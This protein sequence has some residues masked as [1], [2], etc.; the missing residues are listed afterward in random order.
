MA[1]AAQPLGLDLAISGVRKVRQAKA[2][3]TPVRVVTDLPANISKATKNF[4]SDFIRFDVKN[5]PVSE[6]RFWAEFGA[7]PLQYRFEV[8]ED[9]AK[10]LGLTET[11]LSAG[12]TAKSILDLP[13]HDGSLLY[14]VS[15]EK[16]VKLGWLS[17]VIFRNL[18]KKRDGFMKQRWSARGRRS[19]RR[20]AEALGVLFR[21]DRL[22]R[23][24]CADGRDPLRILERQLVWTWQSFAEADGLDHED[25][26]PILLWPGASTDEVSEIAFKDTIH[27]VFVCDAGCMTVG[28]GRHGWWRSF[29]AL[30]YHIAQHHHREAETQLQFY[31][32]GLVYHPTSPTIGSHRDHGLTFFDG[33]DEGLKLEGLDMKGIMRIARPTVLVS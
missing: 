19:R 24:R 29:V 5:L 22:D 10:L 20:A 33:L 1:E 27:T 21:H 3:T 2:V 13:P 18:D 15:G 4:S 9:V 32:G 7:S 8:P 26:V 25:D 17:A 28:W 6:Q 14:L 16:N 31:C 23:D 12:A 11:S 30:A